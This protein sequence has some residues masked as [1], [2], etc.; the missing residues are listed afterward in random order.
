M[1]GEIDIKKL[2]YLAVRGGWPA[3]INLSSNDSKSA[4]VEYLNLIIDDDLDRL[5]NVKRD[6][7]KIR[8][9]LK[10]LAR[11]ESTTVSFSK[12]KDDISNIE[13]EVIDVDTIS[14]YLSALDRLFLFD[15]DE[16]FSVNVRSGIRV[17]QNEKRH[18]A[19]PSLACALLNLSEDKL[20]YDLNTFGFIF[21]AMVE[22][23]LKIYASSFGGKSYHYQDYN[24]REIDHVIELEDGSWC[25]FEIK[26]GA[27][28]I[29]SAAKN[30]LDIKKSI[31]KDGGIPPKVMCVICGLS[32]A[33]YIRPDGVVV[34]P[35]TALKN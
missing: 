19:D 27:N 24:N 30:L 22:R 32:N 31:E 3:N 6:K 10:S 18:F 2:A 11:N 8:L 28:K 5:D 35:I 23:D 12:L 15:N 17:K 13:N 4:L 34:V 16:P 33:A 20:I 26:L 21:E 9:L 14:S 29:E 1:T 25:A 7:R